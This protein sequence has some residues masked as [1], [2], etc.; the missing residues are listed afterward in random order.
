M[1]EGIGGREEPSARG[2]SQAAQGDA[3]CF[4]GLTTATLPWVF[5]W[6]RLICRPVSERCE[7]LREGAE[8]PK[9]KSGVW[10]GHHLVGKYLPVA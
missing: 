8:V 2:G 1:G 5:L 6:S 3:E 10:Q 9:T 4:R 7:T